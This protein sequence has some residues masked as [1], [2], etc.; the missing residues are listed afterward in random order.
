MAHATTTPPPPTVDQEEQL[1]TAAQVARFL[2][3][4]RTW[5]YRETSAGR[6]PYSRI[7]GLVRYDPAEIRALKEKGRQQPGRVVLS[8]TPKPA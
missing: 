1:W 5:V 2:N 7:L 3:V 8:L 6:L 4:S